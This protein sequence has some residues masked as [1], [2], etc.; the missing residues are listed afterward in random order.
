MHPLTLIGIICSAVG[1]FLAARGQEL[2]NKKANESL[3]AQ[4]IEANAQ[5]VTQ[6]SAAQ[7]QQMQS[8]VVQEGDS[9]L[10]IEHLTSPERY[11][12]LFFVKRPNTLTRRDRMQMLRAFADEFKP[13]FDATTNPFQEIMDALIRKGLMT[14]E[15]VANTL[16]Q[17]GCEAVTLMMRNKIPPFDL[18]IEGASHG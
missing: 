12:L 15:G 5:L 17:K 10:T 3:Y 18:E 14:R 2:S 7:L 9:Q 1:A 8:I 16:T 4:L 11:F 6:Q 13:P